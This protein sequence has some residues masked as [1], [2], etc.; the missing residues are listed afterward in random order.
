MGASR[1]WRA[2]AVATSMSLALAAAMSPAV[3]LAN[4]D[5]VSVTIH[6]QL[7][8]EADVPFNEGDSDSAEVC[9]PICFDA[10]SYSVQAVGTAHVRAALGVDITF[11]Y[12]PA[13][14]L[15]NGSVPISVTYTP[16]NDAG[17][18]VSIDVVADITFNGCVVEVICDGDSITNIL[19]GYV[20][21]HGTGSSHTEGKILFQSEGAE[22]HFRKIEVR[23][24]KK[25]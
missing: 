1:L 16:T 9:L 19:N 20:V 22:I 8:F 25:D 15:P 23:P 24:L 10:A 4:P 2:A 11:E 6:R 18:E 7:G 12:D 13:D 5:P 3:A 21:N 14:V 17:D